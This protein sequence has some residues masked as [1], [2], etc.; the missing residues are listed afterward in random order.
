M[1]SI[2]ARFR[3]DRWIGNQSLMKS[4]SGGRSIAYRIVDAVR[5]TAMNHIAFIHHRSLATSLI[6]DHLD[7]HIYPVTVV[8]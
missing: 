7:S 8:L 3:C 5:L 2:S 4:W 6:A 1:L